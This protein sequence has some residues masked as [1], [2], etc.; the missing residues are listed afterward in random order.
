MANEGVD[1][2]SWAQEG[3]E[4]QVDGD[5]GVIHNSDNTQQEEDNTNLSSSVALQTSGDDASPAVG[6][7]EDVGEYNPESVEYNPESVDY[8]PESVDATPLPLAEQDQS[9][10]VTLKPSPQ[11]TSTAQSQL[12]PVSVS[13]PVPAPKKRKTA[14]GFLVGDS[15][16]EEDDDSPT[17]ASNGLPTQPAQLD[18]VEATAA[19]E[20]QALRG[21]H[22]PQSLPSSLHTST[23]APQ[24]Q[25]AVSNVPFTSQASAP[26]VT[27]DAS[28]ASWPAAPQPVDPVALPQDVVTTLEER[29]KQ[30]PRA[31]MDA[32]LDLIA[33][34]RRRN[35]I[36]ALRG[37][38]DRFLVV[39]PQSVSPLVFGSSVPEC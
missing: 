31:A 28:A 13:V 12:A 34:L 9:R 7:L 19:L 39:F 14:G 8:N 20:E 37:V 17:P 21:G 22:A 6:A 10:Q 27:A 25:E 35:D 4:F 11:P 26:T 33:E 24:A 30:D 29:I 23:L 1:Q 36:D 2:T 18:G 15:D 38:Y 16:S 3:D 32:W 5:N